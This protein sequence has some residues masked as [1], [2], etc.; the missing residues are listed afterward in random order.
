MGFNL[1]RGLRLLALSAVAFTLLLTVAALWVGVGEVWAHLRA[2]SLPLVVAILGLSLVDYAIRALRWQLLCRHIGLEIPLGRNT[3]YYLAG[4]ALGM[5]PG[6]VGEAL[7]LWLLRRHHAAAYERT[8]G[9]FLMD[10]L[11]DALPL[12]LLCLIGAWGFVGAYGWAIAA[13]GLVLVAIT[14]LILAPGLAVPLVKGA[15]GAIGRAERPFARLLALLRHLR[16]FRDPG[17]VALCCAM[18]LLGWLAE[19]WGVHLLLAA[20]GSPIGSTE[21]AFVFAFALLVGA[22]PIFPGG[23]GGTEAAMVATL[24]ALGVPLQTAVVATAVTRF[25]TLIFGTLVGLVALPAALAPPRRA[26]QAA[27]IA[28]RT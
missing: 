22:I 28:P 17:L 15:Y 5:T 16:A 19:I 11:T 18:G 4:F 9:L 8:A 26:A 7:R 21:A 24:T 1:A 14:A 27:L 10:R 23:I 6:K 3:L 13:M 25:A 12:F 20:L 2:L